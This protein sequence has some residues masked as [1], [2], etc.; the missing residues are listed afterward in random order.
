MEREEV[1]TLLANVKSYYDSFR[2]N[3]KK[4]DDWH[5]ILKGYS[6]TTLEKNLQVHTGRSSRP[7]VVADLI[8]GPYRDP[9]T[10][11]V[12]DRPETE[13]VSWNR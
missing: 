7:P 3:R 5:K 1:D 9:G 6:F 12:A 13:L 10:R 11:A 8:R 2:V 4:A